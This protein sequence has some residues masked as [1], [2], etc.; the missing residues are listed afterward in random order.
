MGYVGGYTGDL[1]GGA[2][3]VGDAGKIYAWTT[4]KAGT[5]AS[6]VST[7]LRAVAAT[8]EDDGGQ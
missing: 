5:Q 6:P 7:A 1:G 4:S 3:A 2:W 8:R